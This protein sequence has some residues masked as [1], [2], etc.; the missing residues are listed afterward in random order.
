MEELRVL[1]KEEKVPEDLPAETG[2]AK[3]PYTINSVADFVD[4]VS[5]KCSSVLKHSMQAMFTFEHDD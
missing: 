4:L 3:Y 1:L 2:P 5:F